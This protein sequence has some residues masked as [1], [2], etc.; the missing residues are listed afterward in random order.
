MLVSSSFLVSN[1]KAIR[2]NEKIRGKKLKKLIPNI[3]ETSI[4]D[5]FS[6]DPNKVIY[7]FSN[8]HLTDTDKL[9][10]IRGFTFAI[11]PKKIDY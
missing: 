10:L 6:Y 2:K 4:I 5:N 8:Y 3:Y 11:P 7:N 9:L 1:D